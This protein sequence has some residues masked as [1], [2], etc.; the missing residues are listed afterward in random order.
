M[1]LVVV[2]IAMIQYIPWPSIDNEKITQPI[3]FIQNYAQEYFLL[4]WIIIELLNN[5]HDDKWAITLTLN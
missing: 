4:W 2:G 3:W 1:G 5:I